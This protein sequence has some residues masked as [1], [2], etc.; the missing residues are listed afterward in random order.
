MKIQIVILFVC[1]MISINVIGQDVF[2][3][4]PSLQNARVGFVV[5]D[6]SNDSVVCSVRGN[7]LFSPASNTKL[8]TTALALENLPADFHW[9]TRVALYGK[10]K[11]NNVFSGLVVY[12]TTGD[13]SLSSFT[14]KNRQNPAEKLMHLFDSAGIDVFKGDICIDE[15]VKYEGSTP[16]EWL[17]EDL[18]MPWG[19]G[20]YA[21][22]FND[23]VFWYSDED[24]T[25]Q[26]WDT[27]GIN[28][29]VG[30]EADLSPGCSMLSYLHNAVFICGIKYKEKMP[31]INWTTPLMV[32]TIRSVTLFP[33]I[34]EINYESRNM[35]AESLLLEATTPP[36]S[37]RRFRPSADSLSAYWR[38]KLGEERFYFHDGSGMSPFNAVSPNTIV[39]LLRYMDNSEASEPYIESLPVAGEGTL[40]NMEIALPD[41][42]YIRMK[43]GSFT[44]VRCYSGYILAENGTPEYAFS[45]MV[46]D[47]DCTHSEMKREI[48]AF[49]KLFFSSELR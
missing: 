3:D 26:L 7:E 15:Q 14:Y 12:E 31:K 17:F 33:L 38:E 10:V 49:L 2:E 48:G 47:F 21:T 30:A 37:I 8:F 35:W 25:V 46:N 34:K 4:Y 39:T 43:S 13:P 16:G 45:L 19:A 5:T 11:R 29:R 9:E 18:S 40:K 6:L 36:D 42:F 27:A 41:G 24:E 1:L 44:R 32:D 23:N 28:K 22:N 20:V